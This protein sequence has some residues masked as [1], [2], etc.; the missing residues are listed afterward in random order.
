MLNI[1]ITQAW[2]DAH[3]DARIGLLEVSGVENTIASP[4]LDEEK[5][6]VEAD[7]RTSY[8][9]YS[10]QDFLEI[11][12]MSV[13]RAY[14][15]R[16][17]KTYH[18]LQQVESIALKGRSLPNVSPLVDAN[19]AAEVETLILTAGH[20]VAKL[21][22]NVTI[23]I[24]IEGDEMTQMNGKLKALYPDDMVMKDESGIVCSIIYGQ[25]NL[26]PIT[27]NTSHVL[28]VAY[29]PAGIPSALVEKQLEKIKNNIRLF[30]EDAVV[31]QLTLLRAS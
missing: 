8:Q 11:P 16:F 30:S 24:A 10:R 29:V 2:K 28:Y 20:D 23:D 1:T 18:V 31:E 14:Y 9:G 12:A 17:K 19:F 25:D 27:K 3:P 4:K 26:S 22:G 21:A 15:K 6:R 13:Y 7:L 5:R